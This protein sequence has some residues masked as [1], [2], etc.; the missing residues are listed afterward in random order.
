MSDVASP[1]KRAKAESTLAQLQEYTV[2]VADTGDFDS[3]R[4]CVLCGQAGP[5]FV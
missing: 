1:T 4:K 3:I 2:V 5:R